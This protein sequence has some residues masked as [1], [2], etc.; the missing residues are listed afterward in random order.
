MKNALYLGVS[1]FLII[2]IRNQIDYS[3]TTLDNL[4]SY[5]F[6]E[7]WK[8]TYGNLGDFYEFITQSREAIGI[9]KGNKE[10]RV[11]YQCAQE[12]PFC[13]HMW[14]VFMKPCEKTEDP[15]QSDYQIYYKKTPTQVLG[16][17]ILEFN[18][19]FVYKTK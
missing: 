9:K 8:K 17:K 6:A 13:V 7:E 19:S 10:C 3:N 11:Y 14:L 16:T 4:K 2:A 15:S 18:N 1:L 12:R 5:T